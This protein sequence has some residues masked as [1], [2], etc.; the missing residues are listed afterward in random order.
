MRVPPLLQYGV[1]ELPWHIDVLPDFLWIASTL[2]RRSDWNAV[3]SA[4][5]VIDRFVPEG[6]EVVDGRLSSFAHV[7]PDAR[8]LARAALEVE[9][10]TAFPSRFGHAVGLYPHCPALWLYE[11]WLTRNTPDPA[12]GLP[13]LRGVIE[14][15]GQKNSVWTT[16]AQ[17]MALA[18]QGKHG[19]WSFQ[20]GSALDLVPNYPDGLSSSEQSMLESVIR[21]SWMSWLGAQLIN[22]PELKEWPRA[23]WRQNRCLAPCRLNETRREEPTLFEDEAGS[24]DPEP[25]MRLESMRRIIEALDQLGDGLRAKQ[26]EVAGDPDA[27]DPNAV[28]L[29]FASRLY[30]LLYGFLER[31]SAWVPDIAGLHLRPLVD[32]RIVLGWLITRDDPELFR[33]YQ[34]H[35][36][37]NLK[38]LREHVKADLGDDPDE[39]GKEFLSVLDARVNAE[40]D[41]WFQPVNLGSF[42]G[43]SAREM[44]I[45]SG[46]KREYDLFYS[47][48]SSANHGEWPTLREIDT[49]GCQERLHRGHRLGA[50]QGPG[51]TL[52]TGGPLSAIGIAKAGICQAFDYYG[53]QVDGDFVPLEAALSG[54]LSEADVQ[55]DGEEVSE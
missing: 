53:V 10:P 1:Q 13:L 31:P 2:G 7:P 25:L 27:D 50:F 32:A 40:R 29:G 19:K 38:L 41:E 11:D 54:A 42:A 36:R 23:F 5:D 44:A 4:L 14:D 51:R 20:R 15:I 47:P 28:I 37:G 30:R 46:L 6:E 18:R 21:A 43:V 22:H 39:E 24:L 55:A 45:Q 48:L 3:R 8:P 9:A 12:I 16:R 26:L 34:E 49:V 35:G 17:L 33:A 52:T